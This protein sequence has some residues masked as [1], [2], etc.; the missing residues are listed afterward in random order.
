MSRG[1]FSPVTTAA[2]GESHASIKQSRNGGVNTPAITAASG[3]SRSSV[4]QHR[5]GGITVP[6]VAAEAVCDRP[7]GGDKTA[8]APG[9]ALEVANPPSPGLDASCLWQDDNGIIVQENDGDT[10]CIDNA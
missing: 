8:L 3:E 9:Y 6:V 7:D 2:S 10:I 1:G 4:K 5:N